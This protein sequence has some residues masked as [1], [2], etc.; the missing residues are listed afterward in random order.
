MINVDKLAS[1]FADNLYE[2]DGVNRMILQPKSVL[3]G[4]RTLNHGF[5]FVIRGE[6]SMSVNGT[7]YELYP[8]SVFHAAP[9]MYL[10]SQVNGQSEYEYY[11]LFYRYDRAGED[12]CVPELFS[13]YKLESGADPRV[14]EL[15][16][17]LQKQFSNQGGIGKLRIKQLFLSIMVHIF[18][19]YSQRERAASPCEKMV[20]EAIS[21]IQGHYMN[22]MTLD[23]LAK[24][25]G[26]GS[27]RFSYFF[28][29]YTGF[30]P[31]DY[32][33][34]YRLE[35]ASELL[36]SGNYLVRDVAASVG[37]TN[38]LY[39]SRAFKKKFGVSPSEFT[40]QLDNDT[41]RI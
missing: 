19:G 33:I 37:Y 39:F 4:F 18:T 12:K 41:Y 14:V 9:G 11:S 16:I 40:P 8:G 26:V 24:L 23:E 36:R 38:P 28:H 1:I 25:H 29:K 2:I 34:H 10:D 17:M 31:I 32:V 35:R 22:P 30:R 20:E 21:Y 7:V 3:R 5:I 6:A 27:K 13:H 15:L